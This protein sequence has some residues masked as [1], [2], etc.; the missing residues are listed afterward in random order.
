MSNGMSH[1][2]II[3]SDALQ[4]YDK[5]FE[6]YEHLFK[7]IKYVSFETKE[8]DTEHNIIYLYDK[9]KNEMYKSQYEILGTYNKS[10]NIWMWAWSN[11]EFSKNSVY[12]SKKILNYGIDLDKESKYLKTELIFGRFRISNSVQLDM[13]LA[14]A[15]YLSKIPIIF[16]YNAFAEPKIYDGN[17]IE[18]VSNPSPDDFYVT[19]YLFILDYDKIIKAMKKN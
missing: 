12:I 8:S 14:L 18:L 6:E 4:Y 1:G 10:S 11:P 3:V 5:N 2:I 13:H 16:K 17:K 7:D 15:T 19:Y 9:N